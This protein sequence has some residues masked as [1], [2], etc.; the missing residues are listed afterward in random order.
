[1]AL[2]LTTIDRPASRAGLIAGPSMRQGM[3]ISS[4]RCLDGKL[5][6]TIYAKY[7]KGSAL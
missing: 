6:R 7:K 1:M 5:A 3:L 2:R 4:S